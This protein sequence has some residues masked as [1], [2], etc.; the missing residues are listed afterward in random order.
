VKQ[1][2]QSIDDHISHQEALQSASD[3]LRI[4]NERLSTSCN[5]T[6]DA[7]SI[8]GSLERV[9]ELADSLGDGEVKVQVSIQAAALASK[10]TGSAGKQS[11]LADAERL[12]K[13]FEQYKVDLSKT[14]GVL[15]KCAEQWREYEARYRTV[16]DWIKGMEKT[17][18]EK[19]VASNVDDIKT[20][21]KSYQVCCH[22]NLS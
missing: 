5:T 16:D 8:A 1:S 19:G 21:V 3:W 12:Q 22:V 6:G 11:I 2:E 14:R 10:S 4:F 13:A 15:E 18:K 17:V 9:Q 7:A 20:F